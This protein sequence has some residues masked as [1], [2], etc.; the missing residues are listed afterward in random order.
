MNKELSSEYGQIKIHKKVISRIAELATKEIE[1]VKKVGL[2]CY[3]LIGKISKL[4]P[5]AKGI[6]VKMLENKEIKVIIPVV[7]DYKAD[8]IDVAYQI[9]K[10][11]TYKLLNSLNLD[12][13][14]VEI[15]IKNVEK[16]G[17]K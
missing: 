6:R 4:F 14:H 12:S 3:G 10:N 17:G 2:D 5:L 15:K 11:V 9:Q 7:V 8:I 1:G 16:E 13:L